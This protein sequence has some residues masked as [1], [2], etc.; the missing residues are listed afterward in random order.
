MDIND[1]L[2]LAA[3]RHDLAV[4]KQCLEQHGAQIE[5]TAGFYD[6]TAL[7]KACRNGGNLEMS[8]YL[9]EKQQANVQASS[10]WFGRSPLHYACISDNLALVRYL[11][12]KAGA[13]PTFAAP[14]YFPPVF[15]AVHSLDILN[16]LVENQAV[17]VRVVSEAD[18]NFSL[19]HYVAFD[20]GNDC[21]EIIQYLVSKGCDV[22]AS[23]DEGNTPVHTA[24]VND[25]LE[26]VK[27]LI[28]LGAQ[29]DAR[30]NDGLLP[31]HLAAEGGSR[32]AIEYFLTEH[33][34][35]IESL[36]GNS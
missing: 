21:R 31:L 24:A 33:G 2:V 36:D 25:H 30:N 4:V 22:Q 8:K 3:Q 20:G 35:D 6:E 15:D 11:C 34:Q 7:M 32:N 19:I 17:D 9:I 26:V 28:E 16:Y 5:A 14:G 27:F 1:Q 10:R 29:P 23:D 18:L 13:D 12:E